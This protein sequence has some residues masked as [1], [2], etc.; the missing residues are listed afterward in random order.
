[1]SRNASEQDH[2][3]SNNANQEFMAASERI[4]KPRWLCILKQ[5]SGYTRT[6]IAEAMCPDYIFVAYTAEQFSTQADLDD[7]LQIAERATRAAGASGFWI[8]CSCMPE[9]EELQ[10]DVYRISDVTRGC[11]QLVIV[12][13]QPRSYQI[14]L[15]TEQM[16]RQWGNRLWTFPEVLLAPRGKKIMIYTRNT[17][18][19]GI[20][21][22]KNKFPTLAW[23]DAANSRQLIDHY[24][25]NLILSRLELVT[26]ALE[27]LKSRNTY[28][29]L[30]GDLSYALMGLL[31]LRP[32]INESDSG[33]QAF[34]RLSLMNDSDRILERLIATFPANPTQEWHDMEDAY[35]SRLW[36]IEPNI[37]ISGIGHDDTVIVDGAVGTTVRWKGFS[38]VLHSKKRS[39]FRSIVF[40]IV[41]FSP[42][43]FWVGVI[44]VA[45]GKKMGGFKGNGTDTNNPTDPTVEGLGVVNLKMIRRQSPGATSFIGGS[46]VTES[47]ATLLVLGLIP[48]L[49][50]P[51]L[52]ILWYE[53]KLH[54][55]Q[56]WLFGFEGYLPIE[57]TEKMIFGP[58]SK[59]LAWTPFGSALSS[60][61]KN[62]FG[63]CV[64]IDPTENSAVRA[65]VEGARNARP[66]EDRVR[67]ICKLVIISMLTL[68]VDIYLGRHPVYGGDVIQRQ[69]STNC[70]SNCRIGGRYATSYWS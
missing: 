44:L 31:R 3:N 40:N 19:H 53:G 22:G 6:K 63:E 33:F 41:R 43:I 68:V 60:H 58:R 54:A 32:T 65:M 70:L 9:P 45:T 46:G 12:V 69:K 5:G 47:G 50:A 57:V 61:R 17:S 35:S 21:V 48:I 24:E 4:L 27:C 10:K 52:I 62:E 26:I 20:P 42:I 39:I 11:S 49:L 30:E 51:Y 13:G 38:P 55:R 37:Q 23:A 2:A 25:G 66:G 1:V 29:Y 15:N 7:L 67:S 59:R 36:D 56:P 34:A 14:A 18:D 64:G 16:I 8:S 28:Q